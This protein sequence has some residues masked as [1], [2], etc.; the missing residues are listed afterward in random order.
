MRP[1]AIPI[2]VYCLHCGEEYQSYLIEYRP[3]SDTQQGFW[4]CP[5][6]RCGG[7][8]FLFNIFPADPEWRSEHGERVGW[9]DDGEDDADEY[10]HDMAEKSEESDDGD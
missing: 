1:P 6:E 10:N 9:F 3:I 7:A 5:T 2:E 8:G 4:C